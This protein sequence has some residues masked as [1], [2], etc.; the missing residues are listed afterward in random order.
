MWWG[1]NSWI[2]TELMVNPWGMYDRPRR[3]GSAYSCQ[4]VTGKIGGGEIRK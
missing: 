4:R 1:I 3:D 2:Y